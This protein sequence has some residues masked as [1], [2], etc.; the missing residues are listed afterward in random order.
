MEIGP[1]ANSEWCAMNSAT[2]ARGALRN[3]ASVT[4]GVYLRVSGS[5]PRRDERALHLLLQMNQRLVRP[6]ARPQGVRFAAAE[7]AD[8]GKFERERR[9]ANRGQCIVDIAGAPFIDLADKAQRQVHLVFALPFGAGHAA[10]EQ[11]KARAHF[12]RQFQRDEQPD[13]R[14]ALDS[15]RL[16]RSAITTV[17]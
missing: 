16:R 4:C 3:R 14:I 6:H 1:L 10:G 7:I 11:R 8:A 15:G 5:I 17:A 13:H 9:R 12:G 2:L